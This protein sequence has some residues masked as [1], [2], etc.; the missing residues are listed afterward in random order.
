MIYANNGLKTKTTQGLISVEKPYTPE[1]H[2]GAT[3]AY[4]YTKSKF[5]HDQQDLTDQYAFDSAVIE[6]AGGTGDPELVRGTLCK[7]AESDTL[8]ASG[9]CGALEAR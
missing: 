2:W 1:S 6:V 8:D 5:N 3:F 7:I 4:T 9:N